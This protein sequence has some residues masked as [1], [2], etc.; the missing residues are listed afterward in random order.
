[1]SGIA[2][3]QAPSTAQNVAETKQSEDAKKVGK[4]FEAILVRQLLSNSHV[5]GKGAYGDMAVEAL[6]SA[7]TAGGGLGLGRVIEQHLA[8][9]NAHVAPVAA[10]PSAAVSAFKKAAE[11]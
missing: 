6:S 10:H 4:D 3:I 7:V 1:M 8:P 2:K 9:H 5:G 11:K